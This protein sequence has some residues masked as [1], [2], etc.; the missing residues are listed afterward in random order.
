MAIIVICSKEDKCQQNPEGNVDLIEMDDNT[1]QFTDPIAYAK[2]LCDNAGLTRE[3]RGTVALIARDM[4]KAYPAASTF[5]IC[6]IP[7]GCLIC[8]IH[9]INP[10]DALF[11]IQRLSISHPQTFFWDRETFFSTT[12]NALFDTCWILLVLTPISHTKLI[13]LGTYES[14]PIND[15]PD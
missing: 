9:Y 6:M 10:R 2:Y 14:H 3:Q 11:D 1:D 8:N 7:R 13:N 12:G 5:F 15:E 4:Q